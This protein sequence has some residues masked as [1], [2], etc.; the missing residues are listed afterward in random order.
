MAL[1]SDFPKRSKWFESPLERLRHFFKETL[2]LEQSVRMPDLSLCHGVTSSW[3]PFAA[4][5]WLELN[6]FLVLDQRSFLHSRNNPFLHCPL[7]TGK[8]KD[9]GKAVLLQAWSGPEGSRKLRFP[10]YMTTTQD[11]GKIVNLT[12]RPP[13]PSGNAPGTHFC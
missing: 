6:S 2:D 3:V 5:I 7:L 10:D 9:E 11:G 4:V 8:V 12:Q 13:L 1:S